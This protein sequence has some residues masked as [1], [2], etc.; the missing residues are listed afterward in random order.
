MEKQLESFELF[1]GVPVM[2]LFWLYSLLPAFLSFNLSLSHT[3]THPHRH[4]HTRISEI[5][6]RRLTF[7]HC[8][9]C[10]QRSL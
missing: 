6:R 7:R 9:G 3:P 1:I 5:W 4:T 8:V 10:P 2:G